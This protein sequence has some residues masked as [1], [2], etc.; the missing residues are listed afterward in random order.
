MHLEAGGCLSGVAGALLRGLL[1][2][3]GAEMTDIFA[4]YCPELVRLWYALGDWVRECVAATCINVIG[5]A[6]QCD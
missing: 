4:S 1:A 5:D 2:D 3:Q 6:M